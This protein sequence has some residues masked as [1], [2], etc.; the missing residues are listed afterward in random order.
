MLL[1]DE[2]GWHDAPARKGDG[3]SKD[4]L[5]HEDA[6]GVMAQ[7]AVPEVGDDFLRLVEPVVKRVVI[8]D[9]AAPLLHAGQGM[10]I[11]MWHV[12]LPKTY[13]GWWRCR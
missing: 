2:P 13:G 7:C 6:L 5:D 4:G 12:P 1:A 10:M 9:S 8:F 11:R 3:L